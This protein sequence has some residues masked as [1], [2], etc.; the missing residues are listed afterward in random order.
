MPLL[1]I[2][3][4]AS[5]DVVVFGENSVDF[6]GVTNVTRGATTKLPL[7]SFDILPG[8][9]GATAAVGCARLGLQTV[10]VGAFGGDDRALMARA[11]LANEG[12]ELVAFDRSPAP[13]RTAVVLVDETT[14]ERI[15]YEHRHPGLNGLQVP[16]AVWSRGRLLLVDAT[17]VAT[18]TV[19]TRIARQRS[20]PTVVDVDRVSPE[21]L[22]LLRDIDVI[23]AAEDFLSGYSGS[24]E[25]GEALAALSRDL[26]PRAAVVTLGRNGS[27]ALMDGHEVRTPAFRVDVVDATGAGDAFRAGFVAAWLRARTP[28]PLRTALEAANACG[29]LNCRA[30]GAQTA[31]PTWDEVETLTRSGARLGP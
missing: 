4:P 26:H 3:P 6:V 19:A 14:G 23:I 21:T 29:A 5:V 7:R 8:G 2:L 11:H 18:S 10:Y 30:R 22:D 27:L 31:L 25:P 17:D 20:V 24:K 15:V 13:T 28:L 16:D 12:V 1:P 9:Q